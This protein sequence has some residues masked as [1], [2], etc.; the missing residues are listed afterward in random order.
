MLRHRKRWHGYI[1]RSAGRKSEKTSNKHVP[2]RVIRVG[3]ANFASIASQSLTSPSAEGSTSSSPTPTTAQASGP[4]SRQ[5]PLVLSP[6]PP[7][8]A[9]GSQPRQQPHLGPYSPTLAHWYSSG[10]N[11]VSPTPTTYNMTPAGPS[12]TVLST[13]SYSIDGDGPL[14]VPP[15]NDYMYI[16]STRPFPS[17]LSDGCWMDHSC[18]S[19]IFRCQGQ[20][21][22]DVVYGNTMSIEDG[23][24]PLFSEMKEWLC[25]THLVFDYCHY[26]S[27]SSPFQVPPL[28]VAA[29]MPFHVNNQ[30]YQNG[31]IS[32]SDMSY[33]YVNMSVEQNDIDVDS[34]FHHSSA[35]GHGD[36]YF[37]D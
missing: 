4:I 5:P 6:L 11:E 16:D 9:S 21:P 20:H 35:S 27:Q 7:L 31:Y 29:M 22:V 19:E 30:S 24:S 13:T 10:E 8:E 34:V 1:P 33:G 14:F 17:G 12:S 15:I 28:D 3:E 37:I 2:V 32:G 23:L 25:P 26:S 36:H 18:A